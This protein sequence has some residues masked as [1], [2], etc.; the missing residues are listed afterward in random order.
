MAA[1]RSEDEFLGPREVP[2]SSLSI[3]WEWSSRI[4]SISLEFV[5]PI[6]AG[7]WLDRSL[8]TTPGAIILGAI[9]GFAIGMTHLLRIA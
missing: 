1:V 2:R 4:T 6:V 3:G 9:L 8:G 5:L 7:W